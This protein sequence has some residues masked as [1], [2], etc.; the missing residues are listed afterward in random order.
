M[1]SNLWQ[2]IEMETVMRGPLESLHNSVNQ[3]QA[4]HVEHEWILL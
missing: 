3:V 2:L 1:T 4:S